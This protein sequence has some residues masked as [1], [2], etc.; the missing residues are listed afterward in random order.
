MNKIINQIDIDELK[1]TIQDCNLNFLVG[2]GL[3][4]PYLQ[5]LGSSYPF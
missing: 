2:F 5:I 3:S 4:S 1:N